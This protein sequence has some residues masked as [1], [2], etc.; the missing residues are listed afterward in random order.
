MAATR[1]RGFL[2]SGSIQWVN[3]E[4]AQVEKHCE[5]EIEDFG[6]SARNEFD[7]LNEHMHDIFAKDQTLVDRA[8][9]RDMADTRQKC[10]RNIQN[11]GKA[12]RKD[13][14][15]WSEENCP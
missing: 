7:W 11:A 4:N 14:T 1:T 15:D 13:T 5:Q 9:A 2:P 10:N 12:A 3:D 8:Y 6:F